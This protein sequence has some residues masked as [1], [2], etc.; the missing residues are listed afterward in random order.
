MSARYAILLIFNKTKFANPVSNV[1]EITDRA[2]FWNDAVS[3]IAL[4]GFLNTAFPTCGTAME[5][6]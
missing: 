3:N 2:D 4:Y 6:A 5:A 1:A